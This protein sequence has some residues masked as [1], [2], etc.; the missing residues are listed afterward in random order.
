MDKVRISRSAA[1]LLSAAGL[2]ACYGHN[3][4]LA[5]REG[6]DLDQAAQSTEQAIADAAITSKIEAAILAKRGLKMTMINVET[7]DGVVTLTGTVISRKN[8]RRVGAIASYTSGVKHVK[9]RLTVDPS[10][11]G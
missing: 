10:S 8:S 1:L 7:T 6:R 9:N 11:S 3:A 2:A 4:G 5:E